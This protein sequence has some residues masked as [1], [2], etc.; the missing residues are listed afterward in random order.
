MCTCDRTLIHK[1]NIFL[2]KEREPASFYKEQIETAYINKDII[3][4]QKIKDKIDETS[5]P[6][7]P[8]RGR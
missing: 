5:T 4:D 8:G 6:L 2:K 1:I 3:E 7:I